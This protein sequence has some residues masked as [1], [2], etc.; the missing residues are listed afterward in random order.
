MPQLPSV[1]PGTFYSILVPSPF[2]KTAKQALE[3]LPF[4]VTT[5]PDVWHFVPN[6][7]IKR[8]WKWSILIYVLFGLLASIPSTIG[9]IKWIVSE[10]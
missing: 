5:T 6:E 7:K 3:E 2:V 1:G 4:E 10:R 8:L 9:I